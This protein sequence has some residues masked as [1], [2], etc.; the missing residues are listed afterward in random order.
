MKAKRKVDLKN[1]MVEIIPFGK[2]PEFKQVQLSQKYRK[3][4]PEKHQNHELYKD[5]SSEVLERV[6]LDKE[7]RKNHRKNQYH[8]Q[9][10]ERT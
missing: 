1:T 9:H 2:I 8:H 5:P 3:L 6:K 10:T 4:V 7:G